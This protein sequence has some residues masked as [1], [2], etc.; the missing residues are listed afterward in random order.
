MAHVVD[1]AERHAVTD[2]QI[3]AWDLVLEIVQLDAVIMVANILVLV[4]VKHRALADAPIHVLDQLMP[5]IVAMSVTTHARLGVKRHAR[6]DV[7]PDARMAATLDVQ[8]VVIKVAPEHVILDAKTHA[9]QAARQDVRRVVKIVVKTIAKALVIQLAEVGGTITFKPHRNH[10][11]NKR[12][13]Q[14]M[15]G[16]IGQKYNLHCYQGLPTCMQILLSSG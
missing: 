9:R 12:V 2:V 15:E 7:I 13:S 11:G 4:D 3:N 1:H 10:H 16:W 14:S 6:L 8:E 5:Y